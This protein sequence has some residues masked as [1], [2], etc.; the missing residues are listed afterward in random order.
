MSPSGS[1]EHK[2]IFAADL[3]GF[4]QWMTGYKVVDD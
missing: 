2:L 1:E 3:F 4:Q